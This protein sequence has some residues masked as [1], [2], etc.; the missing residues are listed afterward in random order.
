MSGYGL[1]DQ[2]WHTTASPAARATARLPVMALTPRFMTASPYLGQQP[3]GDPASHK[4]GVHE[5]RDA[6]QCPVA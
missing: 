4:P 5:T 2:L 6:P 3:P 1:D